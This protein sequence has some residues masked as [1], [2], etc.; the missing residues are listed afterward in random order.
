MAKKRKKPA[1]AL[2]TDEALNRLF[3]KGA[4]KKLRAV[5][6]QADAEKGRKKRVKADTE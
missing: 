6:E 3:G 1:S 2:T 5:V 4:A